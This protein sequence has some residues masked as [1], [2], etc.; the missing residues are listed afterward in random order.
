MDE[1]VKMITAKIIAH[2]GDEALGVNVSLPAEDF[3][4]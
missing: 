3:L 2:L 1:F 4:A